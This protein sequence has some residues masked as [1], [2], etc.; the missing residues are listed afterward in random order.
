MRMDE[1][2][3]RAVETVLKHEGGY[4]HHPDDPGGETNWGISKRSYPDL[5]IKNLTR[6]Q[7]IA[8]YKRDWWDRYKYGLINDVDVAAKVLD[9]SVNMGPAAAHRALQKSLSF[10]GANL[11]VDG[12]LG[13][14]TLEAVNGADP[15]RLLQVLRWQAAEYYFLLADHKAQ[16]R[17]FLIGW[18]RR[19][20][21]G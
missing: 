17:T 21:Y 11:V 8:I 12:I 16:N 5:D 7:A 18:L 2:F 3:L 1:K 15:K 6:E 14:K 13:P 4:V 10:L 9:M 19:A 20:Y